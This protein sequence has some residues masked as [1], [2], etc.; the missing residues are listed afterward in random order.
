[1]ML[2]D[3]NIESLKRLCNIYNVDKMYLFGSALTSNFTEKSDIDFLVKFKPIELSQYFENYIDF[4]QNLQSL[5][6][7]EVD[8]LEE[9]TLRNPILIKSINRSKELIYG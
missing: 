3:N 6:G 1:M 7:R 5:F 8:L 2:I 4:K 9:Q